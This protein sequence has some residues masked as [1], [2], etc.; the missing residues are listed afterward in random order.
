M[1]KIWPIRDWLILMF[2]VLSLVPGSSNAM[3]AE[4]ALERLSPHAR[5]KA[6]EATLTRLL[7]EEKADFIVVMKTSDIRSR[8]A[9]IPDQAVAA[10]DRH[11]G[12]RRLSESIMSRAGAGIRP[13]HIFKTLPMMHLRSEGR[14][15]LLQLLN[16]PDVES[17]HTDAPFSPSP[18]EALD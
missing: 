14:G 5:E 16:D 1:K 2:S 7:R 18:T 10:R 11:E 9:S 4:Q 15:S 12:Y 13:L 6:D 8:A 17:V 3:T